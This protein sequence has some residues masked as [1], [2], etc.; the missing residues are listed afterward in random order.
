[1]DLFS[2]ERSWGR[3]GEPHRQRNPFRRLQEWDRRL[4]LA[5][6]LFSLTNPC[7]VSICLMNRVAPGMG[8]W[9]CCELVMTPPLSS[10][11][12]QQSGVSHPGKEK[13]SNTWRV[14]SAGLVL[15]D[16][17]VCKWHKAITILPSPTQQ[18]I[19]SNFLNRFF[20]F[21]SSLQ[22][23]EKTQKKPLRYS[24]GCFCISSVV[25]RALEIFLMIH[26][27]WFVLTGHRNHGGCFCSPSSLGW[28]FLIGTNILVQKYVIRGLSK[29]ILAQ[30][31]W[32]E[33]RWTYTAPGQPRRW[34]PTHD[35]LSRN[36]LSQMLEIRCLSQCF[37]Q[38]VHSFE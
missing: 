16:V 35:L 5:Y 13:I 2:W 19:Y 6:M 31:Q 12:V 38:L 28:Y 11:W 33:C 26:T 24:R 29:R 8:S 23:A 32:A 21:I 36:I 34:L 10:D 3:S 4:Y 37:Y 25:W 30:C 17:G 1:M 15:H 18:I 20:P 14:C 9:G 22:I 7:S 27:C